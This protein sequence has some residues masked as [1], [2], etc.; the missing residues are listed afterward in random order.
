MTLKVGIDNYKKVIRTFHKYGIGVMGAFIIG[1][2]YE[3]IP[4]YK[5]LADFVVTSGIDIAQI[6]ILTPLPGT[7]LMDQLMTQERLIFTE[8]PKDWDKYR[9]SYMVH[10]PVG[11]SA[12]MIY[13]GD[14]YV[15]NKLYSFPVY[16]YRLLRSIFAVRNW[17]NFTAIIKF[18]QAL[19]KS[20]KN[21][22][23][24]RTSPELSED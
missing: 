24:Y 10:K 1:N 22:H 12:K 9:F 14:N 18:N 23:Y 16:Q 11:T 17:R 6:S 13:A 7:Q 4:Y 8:F 19:K 2:D 5:K 15:K 20:W 21:S 3:S